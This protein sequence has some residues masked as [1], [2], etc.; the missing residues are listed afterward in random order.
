PRRP[1]P[2]PRPR[3]PSAGYRPGVRARQYRTAGRH[4]A[5]GQSLTW[6]GVS[7]SSAERVELWS[8]SQLSFN[9]RFGGIVA[10][11][12]QLPVDDVVFDGEIVAMEG[13]RTSFA[14]LQRP[15]STA[16]PILF[17]FDVVHLD[18]VDLTGRPLLE[19]KKVL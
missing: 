19:R 13:D 5:P 11:L 16:T 17:V 9:A 18:G 4:P 8:R 10:A 2:C 1:R 15:G 14:A 12:R 6:V 7:P 3:R